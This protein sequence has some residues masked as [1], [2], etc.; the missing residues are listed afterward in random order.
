MKTKNLASII[1]A[2]SLAFTA[3]GGKKHKH[4]DGPAADKPTVT[5]DSDSNAQESTPAPTAATS[6]TMSRDQLLG[7]LVTAC[8]QNSADGDWTEVCTC[9]SK[10]VIEAMVTKCGGDATTVNAPCDLTEAESTAAAAN[11]QPQQ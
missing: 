6:G 10:G 9:A 5:A 3:C 4:N 8:T 1:I 2:A 11:C 7:Q